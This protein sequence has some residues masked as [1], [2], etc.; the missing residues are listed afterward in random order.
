MQVRRKRKRRAPKEADAERPNETWNGRSKLL[1]SAHDLSESFGIGDH[2]KCKIGDLVSILHFDGRSKTR[3]LTFDAKNLQVGITKDTVN[4][5]VTLAYYIETSEVEKLAE[6]LQTPEWEEILQIWKE[7]GLTS[8]LSN[9]VENISSDTINGQSTS[10]H[11]KEY[12]LF[13]RGTEFADRPVLCHWDEI[14]HGRPDSDMDSWWAGISQDFSEDPVKSS[15]SSIM[16]ER[17]FYRRCRPSEDRIVLP[18]S[19][20]LLEN[21]K[22]YFE[23]N[24]RESLPHPQN[25]PH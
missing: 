3:T 24:L 4:V 14:R 1:L 8:A 9:Y 17:P 12:V 6:S 23:E 16:P 10:D 2:I 7:L 13:Y 18:I 5:T 20:P 11:Q 19:F 22:I 21:I 25:P 15:R